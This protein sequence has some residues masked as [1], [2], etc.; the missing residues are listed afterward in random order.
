[1]NR[2]KKA[3]LTAS[4]VVGVSIIALAG[5]GYYFSSQVITPKI[6][7]Y[8]ETYEIEVSKGKIDP[9]VF[10]RMQKEDV[11]IESPFGYK[12]HALYFPVINSR[13]T[14]VLSHGFTY[15]LMGSIKYADLFLKRGFNVLAYDLRYHGKSGGSNFTFGWRDK[16]DL[17]ACVDWARSKNGGGIIGIH[18]ESIGAAVALQYAA[19]D[20]GAAFIIADGSFSD[21][22]RLLAIQLKNGFGLPSFPLLQAASIM[23]RMRGAM[24]FG[25]VSPVR[26]VPRIHAPVLIIHGADDTY[27]PPSMAEELYTAKSGAKKIYLMPEAGHSE[28]LVKNRRKYDELIGGFLREN[29]IE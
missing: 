18:G 10:D 22:K 8:D 1:V 12:I 23:S 7:G 21:L 4:V 25:C 24:F 2:I 15:T 16:Y 6:K 28:S 29:G 3:V 13:G 17:K 14:V 9:A 11:F 5:A 27:I 26:D 20:D 19:I